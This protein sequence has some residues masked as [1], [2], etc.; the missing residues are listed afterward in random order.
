MRLVTTLSRRL[1]GCY[2]DATV[3]SKG[4]TLC[5]SFAGGLKRAQSVVQTGRNWH[6]YFPR[7]QPLGCKVPEL[8]RAICTAGSAFVKLSSDAVS[9][10]SLRRLASPSFVAK[11]FACGVL[12]KPTT[13]RALANPFAGLGITTTLRE[14]GQ[15][16]VKGVRALSTGAL[17]EAVR[18]FL[19]MGAVGSVLLKL[20]LVDLAL[21]LGVGAVSCVFKSEKLYDLVGTG[22]FLLIGGLA[23][24]GGGNFYARQVLVTSL[25]TLWSA[26]LASAL[27][28]R[29]LHEGKDSRFDNVR[30]NPAKF[31]LYWTVQ[32]V[33]VWVTLLPVMM[34][35]VNP[36][37]T[38]LGWMDALSLV[39]WAGGFAIESIADQQKKTFRENPANKGRW[40]D[41]G[42]WRYS[43]HPNYFG[44]MVMWWS[45]FSLSAPA[46]QGLQVLGAVLSPLLV[47]HLLINVSGVPLQEAGN[48]KK[49]Y[50]E[51]FNLQA[52]SHLSARL[53]LVNNK[54]RRFESTPVI[55]ITS[56]F[57]INDRFARV[58][59]GD[60]L[61]PLE[62]IVF[63]PATR[64]GQGFYALTNTDTKG[65]SFGRRTG[66]DHWRLLKRR[67]IADFIRMRFRH[68]YT[69]AAGALLKQEV[70]IPMG[71]TSK[72]V[73]CVCASRTMRSTGS[74]AAA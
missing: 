33:W 12:L 69:D 4:L 24:V 11:G 70:G 71:A 10:H 30:D 65:S 35:N 62:W 42:L 64:E 53:R 61:Q 73:Q 56:F 43:Q 52:F 16:L 26:R 2:V 59:H 74:I 27:F 22:S 25:V 29:V 17:G 48:K 32:A 31:M 47:M 21:Q 8:S 9:A 38:P 34:L 63:I 5:N 45:I 50:H 19:P 6:S 55:A 68:T 58:D 46:L 60:I 20:A 41:T 36:I 40:I 18:N 57:D 14:G 1:C 37:N 23:L 44:E 51:H 67:G 13:V 49:E 7:S 28:S 3:R 39:C 15:P 66:G 54:I 72:E